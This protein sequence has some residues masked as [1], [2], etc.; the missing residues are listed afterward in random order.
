MHNGH[1][2]CH[3][4]TEAAAVNPFPPVGQFVLC[5]PTDIAQLQCN[6]SLSIS[7]HFLGLNG[8]SP[9]TC[10]QLED[11]APPLD[12]I[13]L[14]FGGRVIL[15]VLLLFVVLQENKKM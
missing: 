14:L 4:S 7:T 5:L 10:F 2:E 3:G 13:Q 12:L 1:R 9:C 8:L 15:R 11:E 6:Y